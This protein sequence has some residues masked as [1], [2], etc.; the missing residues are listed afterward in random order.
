MGFPL[1]DGCTNGT[2]IGV[3]VC[4]A[5]DGS[6]GPGLVSFILV[7]EEAVEEP[8]AVAPAVSVCVPRCQAGPFRGWKYGG[9]WRAVRS[10][11][12]RLSLGFGR[13]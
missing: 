3:A 1:R 2:D 10:E 4:G 6:C 11:P 8:D 9:G 13:G 5:A 7:L 12:F